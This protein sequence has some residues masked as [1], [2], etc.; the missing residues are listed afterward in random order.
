MKFC[1]WLL[2]ALPLLITACKKGDDG[3]GKIGLRPEE[4][5]CIERLNLRNDHIINSADVATANKLF[6]DNNIDNSNYRYITYKSDPLTTWVG[7][8]EYASGVNILMSGTLFSFQKGVL[9]Y[10]PRKQLDV[11][12]LDTVPHTPLNYLKWMFLNNVYEWTKNG[13]RNYLDTCLNAQLCYYPLK[14]KVVKAW[15]VSGKFPYP[16]GMYNDADGS[17]ISFK[18]GYWDE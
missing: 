15:R 13:D 2:I 7:V 18:L 16:I 11:T 8:E 1:L 5:G 10:D 6:A 17:I 14:D 4:T 12:G 9:A 3:K